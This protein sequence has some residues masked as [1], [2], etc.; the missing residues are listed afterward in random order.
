MSSQDGEYLIV[1]DRSDP[2]ETPLCYEGEL[3]EMYLQREK[4]RSVLR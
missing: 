2:M 3:G 4:K 1:N